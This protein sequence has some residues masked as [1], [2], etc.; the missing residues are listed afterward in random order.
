MKIIIRTK[1]PDYPE[2]ITEVIEIESSYM[3]GDSK[4]YSGE[5]DTGD[6]ITIIIEED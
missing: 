1:Q 6:Q 4:I 3:D 2:T 5:S